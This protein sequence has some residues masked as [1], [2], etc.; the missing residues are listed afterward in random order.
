MTGLVVVQGRQDSP[1]AGPFALFRQA[2]QLYLWRGPLGANAPLLALLSEALRAEELQDPAEL[3][4]RLA[5]DPGARLVLCYETPQDHLARAMALHQPP[6]AALEDWI[7]AAH[8]LLKVLHQHRHRAGLLDLGAVTAQGA[9]LLA[10][11]DLPAETRADLTTRLEALAA[12]PGPEMMLQ[13]LAQQAV[14]DHVM[15]RRLAGE[16]EASA[17]T[18]AP[19]SPALRRTEQAFGRWQ[20]ERAAGEALQADLARLRGD[21][22]VVQKRM[23]ELQAE[24]ERLYEQASGQ[25]ARTAELETELAAAR[26]SAAQADAALQAELETARAETAQMR[27]ARDRGQTELTGLRAEL[28]SLQESGGSARA[29]LEAQLARQEA[30]RRALG[31]E[32]ARLQETLTEETEARRALEMQLAETA[33]L[34]QRL[35]QLQQGLAASEK[36]LAGADHDRATLEAELGGLRRQLEATRD[37]AAALATRLEAAESLSERRR[38]AI[39]SKNERIE[40]LDAKRAQILD[41]LDRTA[42]G[43]RERKYQLRRLET[44]CSQLEGDLEA[45]QARLARIEASRG[46]RLLMRLRRLTGR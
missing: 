10:Q 15:A 31:A 39:L 30:D 8:D 3:R 11:A 17:L 38:E 19:R 25:S 28:A 23:L 41:N 33:G 36:Q 42:K 43:S 35:H 37:N 22:G 1:E 40:A 46:Y 18:R 5:E 13:V 45:A 7:A 6:G 21:R 20:A 16:L 44:R 26:Q 24:L 12:E 4:R 2:R 32:L 29:A 14:Q 9:E 27:R 34:A